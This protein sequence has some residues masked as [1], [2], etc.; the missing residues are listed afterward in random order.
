MLKLAENG[1]TR[2]S[3]RIAPDANLVTV[4]A[5]A[6][7]S[8]VLEEITRARFNIL[9]AAETPEGPVI[10]VGMADMARAAGIDLTA[11]G[12]EGYALK[13]AGEDLL[14][15]A[16]PGRGVLYGVYG[17]LE[18]FCGCR[19]FTED[20]K[21]IPKRRILCI[22][23]PDLTFVPALEYRDPYFRGYIDPDLHA[24]WGSNSKSAPLGARYGWNMSYKGFV[25]TFFQLVPPEKYYDEHPEYF[26]EIDGGRVRPNGT[27]TPSQLCLTNPEVA[28]IATAT[29]RQ[30][31]AENPHVRIISVS[32]NDWLGNCQCAACR[33]ADEE[34]GSP[35]GTLLRFVNAIAEALEPEFPNVVFDTLA[36][37]YTRPIP[38]KVRP[39]KNVC[40]RL[41]SIEACFAHPFETCDDDRSV[42]LPDGSR[43]DF[44]TDLR[45]WGKVCDRVY[46][47]DYTTCF[48]HYP[49]PHPNWHVLQPNMRAFRDNHVKGV[50]EQANGASRGGTDFNELREYVISRLL[51]D[52]DTDV[53]R[54]IREFTDCY[55]GPAAP[56]VRQ[57][58]DELCGVAERE[59]IHVGF[60]D[61]LDTPLF[62]PEV[63]DR[64]QACLDRA[65]EAVAG[66]PL[67][68]WRI[69]KAG[70]SLRWV[71]MKRGTMG[72]EV[73]DPAEMNRFFTDWRAY[74]LTRI[75]EW[76]SQ[77]TT[78]RAMLNGL[79][80]GT[81]FYDH[82]AGDG[83]EEL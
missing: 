11:L 14:I 76:C 37:N 53:A 70:L 80:R 38:T 30:W 52:P 22:P 83:P 56:F 65:A 25:H 81:E 23:E 40:V 75:D 46:I 82:W 44:I 29:V 8:R 63:L 45:N 27:K 47:W 51:W 79:W 19:F 13:T 18:R 43:S 77:E 68:L 69:G 3:I 7:L 6:E 54:H 21:K 72:D 42:L 49:A 20:V 67:R 59:N 60:N 35:A 31:I 78:F 33:K 64:L 73:P 17:L 24:R 50:F 16:N 2:Y 39:R 61:N 58:I 74:G 66:D 57:Y 5:A 28:K 62:R 26:S 34:E 36:Y 9:T 41:C 12:E 32:Q 48:A 71:R 15:A 4:H 10:A 55:Y 1:S